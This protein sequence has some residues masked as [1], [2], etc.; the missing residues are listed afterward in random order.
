M[1]AYDAV[2]NNE[3]FID[4]EPLKLTLPEIPTEPDKLG[5]MRLAEVCSANVVPVPVVGVG[6][7]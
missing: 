7:P 2:A 1:I 4:N 5:L 6:S 3:P